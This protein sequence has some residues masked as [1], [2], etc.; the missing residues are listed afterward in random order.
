M[1]NIV[2][3]IDSTPQVRLSSSEFLKRAK[4]VTLKELIKIDRDKFSSVNQDDIQEV[5][6]THVL[7]NKKCLLY[8]KSMGSLY[9]E[10]TYDVT[11]NRIY[12]DIYTKT[13]NEVYGVREKEESKDAGE[14]EDQGTV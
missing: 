14:P 2:D 4:E 1:L 10:V 13:H 7:G 11:N 6:F 12:V 5:W 3:I 8:C 9:A